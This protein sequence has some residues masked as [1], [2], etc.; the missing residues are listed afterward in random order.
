MNPKNPH[1]E[2]TAAV[3]FITPAQALEMIK[4]NA[5]NQRNV[6]AKNLIRIENNFR[7][8]SFVLNGESLIRSE[9]KR[10]LD[11][12]HRLHACVNTQEGFWTVFVDNIPDAYFATIDSGKARSF[13]DVLKIRGDSYPSLLAPAAQ[14]LGEYMKSARS[15]GNSRPLSNNELNDVVEQSPQLSDS[16]RFCSKMVH[17]L[18]SAANI[19]WLHF[20]ATDGGCG[21][22]MEEFLQ[23]LGSGTM[24]SDDSPVYWLRKRL[25][26]NRISKAKLPAREI[27]ALIIKAWNAYAS[28]T[29]VKSLKWAVAEAFPEP[30]IVNLTVIP[31]SVENPRKKSKVA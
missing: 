15:V 27:I 7:K 19:A 8:E 12:Q 9:S 13:A 5:E 14:R 26:A 1:P 29:P 16:V 18:T 20:L 21:E 6:S 22:R 10:I 23:K 28:G 25:E 17:G 24:L 11:G 3:T 31:G 2:V 4:A 30:I